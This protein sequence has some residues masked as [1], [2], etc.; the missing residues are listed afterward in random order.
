MEDSSSIGPVSVESASFQEAVTLLE[1]KVV[2]NQLLAV[3]LTQV[4]QGVV[5]P[6][7]VSCEFAYCFRNFF[8]DLL[9]L[10]IRNSW[11]QWEFSKVSA[12]SDSGASDE[13]GV[14]RGQRRALE[15]GRVHVRHVLV[16]LLVAVV[17]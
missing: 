8:L 17:V 10:I 4:V 14:F 9:S 12:D 5:S 11:P 3:S 6:S 7:E 15:L 1:E 2:V 13:D 16:S